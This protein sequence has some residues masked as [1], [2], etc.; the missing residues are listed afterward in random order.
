MRMK[1]SLLKLIFNFIKSKNKEEW[2]MKVGSGFQKTVLGPPVQDNVN[3]KI[4]DYNVKLLLELGLEQSSCGIS[5]KL[6][7][8]V[9]YFINID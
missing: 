9:L 7:N 2:N 5:Q 3:V 4:A 1:Y 8:K 6:I